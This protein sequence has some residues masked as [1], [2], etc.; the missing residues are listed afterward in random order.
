[1]RTGDSDAGVA[2]S[3]DA[4]ERVKVESVTSARRDPPREAPKVWDRSK[5]LCASCIH[6]DECTYPVP[7]GGVWNCEECE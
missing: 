5:G 4:A 3:R 7:Q 6:R 2:P 1:M